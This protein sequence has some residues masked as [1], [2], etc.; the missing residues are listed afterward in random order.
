M[1]R[2][3]DDAIYA[4]GYEVDHCWVG[5]VFGFYQDGCARDYGVNGFEAGCFHGFSGFCDMLE[6]V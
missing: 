5:R 4:C 3:T 6:V 2:L 1:E